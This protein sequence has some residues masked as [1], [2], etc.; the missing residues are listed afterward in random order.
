[1]TVRVIT[2][3]SAEPI[4][5]AEAKLHL[6]VETGA[7]ADD[8]LI[9]S[10][11]TVARQ[12]AENYTRRAFVKRTLELTLPA[13]PSGG[14]FCLPFPPLVSVSWIKYVDVDGVLQTKLASEYQVDTYREPGLIKPAYLETWPVVTRND[15]NAIQV[16]YIAGYPESGSPDTDVDYAANIPEAIK[17][18]LKIRI[19][20][21]YENR[22]A[23]VVGVSQSMIHRDFIDG[24]LDPYVVDLF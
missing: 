18:W 4:T 12:Y 8:S 7:T 20:T 5:L 9:T 15:F 16:R 14:V 17:H 23:I 24:L 21:L 3:P 22:E 10:M 6:R 19:G 13:I 11:I 1:M 2:E